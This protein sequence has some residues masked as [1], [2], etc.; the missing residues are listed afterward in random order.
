[1]WFWGFFYSFLSVFFQEQSCLFREKRLN[2][3]LV[4]LVYSYINQKH[5]III[6]LQ[7]IHTFLFTCYRKNA[8]FTDY[9]I[10]ITERKCVLIIRFALKPSIQQIKEMHW[11]LNSHLSFIFSLI[12]IYIYIYHWGLQL[13][14]Q[15]WGRC[16]T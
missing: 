12:Y 8:K 5:W 13:P 16:E 6:R 11:I 15:T 7:K 9:I 10:H 1:M 2:A 3:C 14:Q 4:I